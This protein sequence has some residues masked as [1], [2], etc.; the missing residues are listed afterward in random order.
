MYFKNKIPCQPSYFVIL[1][2]P[3]LLAM[4]VLEC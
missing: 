3:R 1:Q 2:I 4:R